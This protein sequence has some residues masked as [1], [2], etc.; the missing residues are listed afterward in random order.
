M[1]NK[2]AKNLLNDQDLNRVN[3]GENLDGIE[4]IKPNKKNE[5]AGIAV[6]TVKKT[7]AAKKILA[8]I[9]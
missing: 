8:E 6:G 1:N 9:E 5:K 4:L 3:G 2:C 7:G